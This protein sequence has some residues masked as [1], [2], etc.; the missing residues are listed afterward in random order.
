MQALAHKASNAYIEQ[1]YVTSLV[2]L[3]DQDVSDGTLRLQA[4]EGRIETISLDG[5]QP[6]GLA[7]IF[8]HARGAVLN[9]R[10]LE[11]GMEQID[12]LPSRRVSIDIQPGT[13][14]GYSRVVLHRIDQDKPWRIALG[15]DNSGQKGTGTRQGAL[16]LA[17]DSPLGL[18]DQWQFETSH[19]L[20]GRRG[21]LS[22]GLTAS[23]TLPYGDWRFGYRYA[24]SD[25]EQPLRVAD[26]NWPYLGRVRQHVLDLHR[27]LYRDGDSTLG[28]ALSLTRRDTRTTFAGQRLNVSS[29][30]LAIAGSGLEYATRLGTGYFTLNPSVSR[31]LHALGASDDQRGLPPSD[32][33]RIS[34]AAS[35][36]LPLTPTISYLTSGYLQTTPDD[37]YPSERISVGG[38]Y[39]VRGFKDTFLDANRGAYWRNQIDWTTQTLP[40]V[41]QPTLSVALD[42]GG[43]MKSRSAK[44][45]GL[46]GSAIMLA[47]SQPRATQSFSLGKPLLSPQGLHPDP[48]V[49][50]WQA[51]FTL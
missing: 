34:L 10:T 30:T 45:G 43:T 25:S 22:R 41:G 13:R 1:G 6:R 42:A 51:S 48:W 39:S 14:Q 8:P 33:T 17:L 47:L 18:Y 36:F 44:G 11:Q 35:G 16:G 26:R 37:L 38:E 32:F 19:D 7:M 31:G 50:Y 15:I 49:V 20:E 2:Y 24:R 23:V 9:L 21:H 3:P 28:W 40:L 12:R 5:Q 29:P 27:T 4:Q 46:L